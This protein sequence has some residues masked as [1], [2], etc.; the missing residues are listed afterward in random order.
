MFPERRLV[1]VLREEMGLDGPQ[2]DAESAGG[3]VV[4]TDTLAASSDVPA[5]MRLAD[6]S[7][8]AVAAAASD[9][10]A[11]GAAPL[12]AAVS[13]T[14]PPGGCD[15]SVISLHF[16]GEWPLGMTPN[17]LTCRLGAANGPIR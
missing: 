17:L 8:K 1:R 13:M 3:L 12:A 11:K 10:A 16:P 5:G 15:K 6:V 14:L 2:E 7:R 4:A 9:F